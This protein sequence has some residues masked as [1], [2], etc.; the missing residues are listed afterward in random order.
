M[1]SRSSLQLSLQFSLQFVVQFAAPL[2]QIWLVL[3][4]KRTD[5][6]ISFPANTSTVIP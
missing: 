4:T 3:E 1:K 6:S 2:H 5:V